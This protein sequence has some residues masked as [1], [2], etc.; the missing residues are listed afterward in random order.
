MGERREPGRVREFDHHGVRWRAVFG[1][2]GAGGRGLC[3]FVPLEAGTPTGDDRRDRRATLEP[4]EDF[5]EVS[6]ERL[7]ELLD[8]GTALTGT[9]RRLTD[10]DG[11]L[12]LVQSSGPVWA[13]GDVAA[14]LT[15]IVLTRLGGDPLR[16]ERPTGD[17]SGADREDLLRI[18][19]RATEN[20]TGTDDR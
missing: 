20:E 18:V 12:W 10:R 17:A 14:G 1:W 15:G 4:G 2:R 5:D 6:D 11:A 7:A 9:E 16:L 8:G 3:Y 19:A 13:E